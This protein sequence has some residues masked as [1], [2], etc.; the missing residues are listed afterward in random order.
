[1]PI[2]RGGIRD[3]LDGF[4]VNRGKPEVEGD[5]RISAILV[6]LFGILLA[7]LPFAAT[8]VTAQPIVVGPSASCHVTD[9][10]FTLCSDGSVEWSD[11]V[12]VVF[13]TGSVLY[14]DQH[15]SVRLPFVENQGQVNPAVR[16]Y[17]NTFAGT[18]FVDERGLTY[19]LHTAVSPDGRTGGLL[20]VK[21]QFV[22]V[23]ALRPQGLSRS[24]T[25]VNFFVGSRETWRSDVVTFDSVS[26]G[27]VWPSIWVELRAYGDNVEKLFWV[28]P[29]GRSSEIRIDVVGATHLAIR[30]DGG[31]VIE[32]VTGTVAMTRPVAYQD[33]D[34]IRRPVAAS[35]FLE[36]MS[37]G[38]RVGHYDP[39]YTLVIDPLLASTFIGGSAPASFS[40]SD[41]ITAIAID[42]SGNV[43]VTGE[44]SSIDY[45]V[46][47]GAFDETKAVVPNALEFDVVVSKL[48]SDLTSLIASTFIGGAGG[49]SGTD[50]ALDAA[51]NVVVSGETSSLDYPTTPGAFE[52]VNQ[53]FS[54]VFISKFN[55]GLSSLLASTLIRG[56]LFEGPSA[57]AVD[58]S[59]NIF[60]AGTTFSNDYPTTPSAFDVSSDA[61]NLVNRDGFVSKL[62]PDLSILL[63]STFIGGTNAAQNDPEFE[64]I[65]DMALDSVGNVVVTGQT[66]STDFP[67]TAVAFDPTFDS[68]PFS[69]IGFVSKLDSDLTS[70]LASTFLEGSVTQVT[71]GHAVAVDALGNVFVAGLTAN[72]DYPTTPGAFDVSLNGLGDTFV[73]KL[74]DSLSSLLASTFL[75]GSSLDD[76]EELVLDTPGD[77][78]VTG[79]T[80]SSDFPV[81]S[82]ALDATRDGISDV[83]VSRLTNDLSSLSAS[84]YIGGS[85]QE[86]TSA[87]A[88]DSTG[89]VYLVGVTRS[90]DYPTTSGAFDRTL[91]GQDDGFVTRVTGDLAAAAMVV[92]PTFTDVAIPLI[93]TTAIVLLINRRWNRRK[94]E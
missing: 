3:R 54:H 68:G 18:V 57:L 48:S 32:T 15:T 39:R 12:P 52:E 16:F 40:S 49:E 90:A 8:L 27:E 19:A 89:S 62:N 38:F 31:L 69:T 87:L 26:F 83:F 46:T 6:G 75:G 34:W 23:H 76:V 93:A 67:T 10:A 24:D 2:A 56:S 81:S 9:G 74:D 60:V 25:V 58:S 45:P 44:S 7:G 72:F 20:V 42:A 85:D 86:T 11:I 55:N 64:N 82:D 33:V 51:G 29:G 79:S 1:M 84:T 17:A 94:R 36:D 78:F 53:G 80:R 61:G 5:R 92:I 59:G 65:L 13:P 47:S 88:L 30:E 14:A 63:A 21:E 70:L 66:K 4:A 73:S 71:R 28:N 41:F 50:I 77:V 37:Y 43:F 35:Y 22:G 91:D